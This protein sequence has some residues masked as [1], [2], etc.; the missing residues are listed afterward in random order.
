MY[1]DKEKNTEYYSNDFQELSKQLNSWEFL[2]NLTKKINLCHF[3]SLERQQ[4]EWGQE[5]CVP[6]VRNWFIDK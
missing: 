3:C 5:K 1:Y 4:I 6:D 2:D